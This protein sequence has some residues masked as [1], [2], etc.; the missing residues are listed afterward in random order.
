MLRT[1]MLSTWRREEASPIPGRIDGARGGLAEESPV[2]PGRGSQNSLEGAIQ[3]ALVGESV[4][5]RCHRGRCLPRAQRGRGSLGLEPEDVVAER[6][7]VVT[8][9]DPCRVDRMHADRGRHAG[10]H[11]KAVDGT[12]TQ[13]HE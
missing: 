7:T 8:P 4:L 1:V 5:D 9:E 11:W 3:V 10:N 13:V 6:D 12:V 2:R